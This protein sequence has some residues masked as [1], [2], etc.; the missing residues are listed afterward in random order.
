MNRS[1]WILLFRN[2]LAVVTKKNGVLRLLP[3][4]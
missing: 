3:P 1:G 2:S 4:N